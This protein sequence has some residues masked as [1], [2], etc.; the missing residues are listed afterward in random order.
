MD[1]VMHVTDEV[2]ELVRRRSLDP[3]RDP[4]GMRR[5]VEDVVAD[6]DERSLAGT[7]PPVL[8]E[9]ATIK[10]VLDAVVGFGPLQPYLDD[11]EVEELWINEP[12]KVFVAKR[13]VAELTSTVLTSAAVRDLVERMLK[14]SG[15]RVDLSSL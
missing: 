2:R 5:L 1:A 13:G 10:Q 3:V 14:S 4:A 9:G 8:D 12:G 7:L 6:Y 11:P 15:R